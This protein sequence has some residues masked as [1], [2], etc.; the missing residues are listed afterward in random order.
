MVDMEVL[1]KLTYY[2]EMGIIWTIDLIWNVDGFDVPLKR[3][4]MCVH[5]GKADIYKIV[6]YYKD[7]SIIILYFYQIT[8]A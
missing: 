5:H 6:Y 2:S 3:E 8:S 4:K 7:Q 1:T